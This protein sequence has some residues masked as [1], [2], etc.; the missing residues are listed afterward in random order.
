[1]VALFQF[2]P[3]E[4]ESAQRHEQEADR[5]GHRPENSREHPPGKE[6]KQVE[7]TGKLGKLLDL[8]HLEFSRHGHHRQNMD[9]DEGINE[10]APP[11]TLAQFLHRHGPQPLRKIPRLEEKL[12]RLRHGIS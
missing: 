11:Q 4:G 6:E 3:H 1:M 9:S 7:H 2:L 10:H 5:S 8:L 12:G